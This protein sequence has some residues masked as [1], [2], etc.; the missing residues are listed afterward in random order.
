VAPD[1]IQRL[2]D[3]AEAATAARYEHRR[4]LADAITEAARRA[5]AMSRLEAWLRTHP[6]QQT[7]V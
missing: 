3:A 7:A 2:V 6:K 5:E 1:Y 4:L